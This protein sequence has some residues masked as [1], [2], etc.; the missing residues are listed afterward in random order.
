MKRTREWLV[1]ASFLIM[2]ATLFTLG[3]MMSGCD[4]NEKLAAAIR[5]REKP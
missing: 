4:P 2:A 5:L 1:T 3:I